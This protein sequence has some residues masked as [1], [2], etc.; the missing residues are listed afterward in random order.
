MSFHFSV[1]ITPDS[2]WPFL[3]KCSRT[4]T[5]TGICALLLLKVVLGSCKIYCKFSDW[6][7]KCLILRGP[8][9]WVLCGTGPDT[10]KKSAQPCLCGS[11]ETME[12]IRPL[13]EMNGVCFINSESSTLNGAIR[14]LAASGSSGSWQVL[15]ENTRGLRPRKQSPQAPKGREVRSAPWGLGFHWPRLFPRW[16]ILRGQG[17]RIF[18]QVFS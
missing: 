17:S 11:Y 14:L 12:Q 5:T 18:M 2:Q 6:S 3:Y 10:R 4:G 16:S 7:Q 8:V 15:Q 9:S 1:G 13:T